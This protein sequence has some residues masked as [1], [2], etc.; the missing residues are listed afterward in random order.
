MCA[1]KGNTGEWSG[2]IGD[3]WPHASMKPEQA[4]FSR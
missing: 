2:N 4:I 3:P 1:M